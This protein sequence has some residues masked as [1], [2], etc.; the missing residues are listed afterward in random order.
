MTGADNSALEAELAVEATTD[1]TANI[2]PTPSRLRQLA[3]TPILITLAFRLG[4]L[5][6]AVI[7][8]RMGFA[9]SASWQAAASRPLLETMIEIAQPWLPAVK[10][11]RLT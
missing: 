3:T 1:V 10:K 4:M 11:A 2:E 6:A 5:V 8:H 7:T 9:Q